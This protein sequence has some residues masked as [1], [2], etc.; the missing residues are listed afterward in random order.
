MFQKN[1]TL[2]E[3]IQNRLFQTLK[4][5]I[6]EDNICSAKIIGCSILITGC[7]VTL[8]FYLPA[9]WPAFP[10]AISLILG[11]ATIFFTIMHT[12]DLFYLGRAKNYPELIKS[13]IKAYHTNEK[14]FLRQAKQSF[15]FLTVLNEEEIQQLFS[16]PLNDQQLSVAT[17]IIGEKGIIT[18]EDYLII[19]SLLSTEQL[20]TIKK[21][22]H[23]NFIAVKN[24]QQ[25]Q[26]KTNLTTFIQS[27]GLE[28]K[29]NQQKVE[30][31]V[32]DL[33]AKKYPEI[34]EEKE[35]EYSVELKKL[36]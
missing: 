3:K 25:K 22:E 11:L 1:Y 17:N 13:Y 6:L 16:Y 28:R 4:K 21:Q 14:D 2:K 12:E 36:L 9:P 19:E 35:I 27:H 8:G 33:I 32:Q 15:D 30:D 20:Q 23:E 26:I 31:C 10:I 24:E 5:H 18:Y 34:E 29:I 7:L